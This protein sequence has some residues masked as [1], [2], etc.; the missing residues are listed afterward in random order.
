MQKV[1]EA[2]I[3]TKVG[4]APITIRIEANDPIQARKLIEMRP[5]FKSFMAYPHQIR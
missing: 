2:K 3:Y 5:E 1:Y 4:G